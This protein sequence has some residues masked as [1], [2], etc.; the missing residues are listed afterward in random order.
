MKF[1]LLNS[2]LPESQLQFYKRFDK[3]WVV[4][5]TDCLQVDFE[6]GSAAIYIIFNGPWTLPNMCRDCR[7]HYEFA[8]GNK[9]YK[10]PYKEVRKK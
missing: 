9:L 1:K 3:R 6:D 8:D 10:I 4:K 7:T 5:T 2:Y